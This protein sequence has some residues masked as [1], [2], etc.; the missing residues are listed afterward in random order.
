MATSARQSNCWVKNNWINL[1]AFQCWFD[2]FVTLLRWT[3]WRRPFE[4][5]PC[6]RKHTISKESAERKHTERKGETTKSSTNKNGKIGIGRDY[7]KKRLERWWVRW[8]TTTWKWAK[9]KIDE[10]KVNNWL[11]GWMNK[12]NKESGLHSTRTLAKHV[13]HVSFIDCEYD[14]PILTSIK[15]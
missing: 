7:R 13:R 14:G 11:E 3:L 9:V 6:E 4:W 8:R 2:S 1:S 5:T 15:V 12:R 10:L